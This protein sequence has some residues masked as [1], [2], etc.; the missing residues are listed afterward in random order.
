[1]GSKTCGVKHSSG[2]REGVVADKAPDEAAV[3]K[4]PLQKSDNLSCR[5]TIMPRTTHELLRSVITSSLPLNRAITQTWFTSVG[6][7]TSI[8]SPCVS[9]SAPSGATGRV[10]GAAYTRCSVGFQARHVGG[11]VG[12]RM[13]AGPTAS[14]T[15]EGKI[16]SVGEPASA[17]KAS[18]SVESWCVRFFFLVFSACEGHQHERECSSCARA[19]ITHRP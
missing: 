10:I 8:A 7:T 12:K 9:S 11:V 3:K 1:M 17:S 2:P 15:C 4:V 18:S 6:S 5:S 19:L 14:R 13:Y 16:Q